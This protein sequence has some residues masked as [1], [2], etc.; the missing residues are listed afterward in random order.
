MIPAPI[1][2]FK[3]YVNIQALLSTV[4]SQFTEVT[5]NHFRRFEQLTLSNLNR[6]NIFAGINNS[7]KTSVLEAIYLL[8]QHNSTNAL[9][10]IEKYR[11]KFDQDLNPTWFKNNMSKEIDVSGIFNSKSTTLSINAT[12]TNEDIDKSGYLTTLEIDASYDNVNHHSKVHIFK[13]KPIQQFFDSAHYLCNA[14]L[15]SPYRYNEEEL[16]YAH[17]KAVEDKTI[18]KIINFISKEIDSNIKKIELVDVGGIQ[19]FMVT[20]DEF[21][22]S[23]DITNYGE[24]V[25]RIFEIAL[26]FASAKGGIVLI[27][28]FESAIHKSLLVKFSR[29]VHQLAVEFNIQVFLTSHSKEC[30]DSFITNGCDISQVSAYILDSKLAEVK[31]TYVSGE[32]LKKYIELLDFDLRGSS[33]E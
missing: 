11:A 30:I 6:I 16:K 8:S 25:Q 17:L 22:S 26:L 7:G 18:D 15:S 9:T 20:S 31:S 28:E 29:F 3:E 23:K 1:N 10:K 21:K 13:D 4:S 5:I 27:D 32:K 19:R 14:T 2:N 33:N 24:G 12:S